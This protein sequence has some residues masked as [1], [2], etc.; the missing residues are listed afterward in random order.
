MQF[1]DD[2]NPRQKEAVVHGDGPLLVVAGA[3]SGKTRVLTYRIAYLLK[4]NRVKPEQV[5]A[6][7][8]TN[9][10]AREMES[11]IV[12]LLGPRRLP[13]LGTFHANCVKLLRREIEPLGF[14]RDFGIY[15]TKDQLALLRR[16]LK[17]MN[18]PEQD[19]R[20]ARILGRISRAKGNLWGPEEYVRNSVSVRSTQEG[21]IYRNYQAALQRCRALDFDDIINFTVRLLEQHPRLLSHWQERFARILIDEYQDVNQAQYVLVK[22]L[23]QGHRNITAVGDDDQS[24]YGFR[25]ADSG[26]LLRFEEDFPDARVVKLEENYRST[27]IILEAANQLVRHNTRRKEKT[28]W[29]GGEEGLPITIHAA[30]DEADEARFVVDRIRSRAGDD[31]R[32]WSDY[33]ILYRTNAQSRL[34]EDALL[35][36]G[37]PYRLVGGIRFYER[38]VVK[39]MLAYLRLVATPDDSIA[40]GRIINVPPR[41]LGKT[42]LDALEKYSQDQGISFHQ[43][44]SRAADVAG[45]SP[46]A[47]ERLGRFQELIESW[48]GEVGRLPLPELISLIA[49][50]SGYRGG[51]GDEQDPAVLAELDNLEEFINLAADYVQSDQSP[52]LA[53]FLAQVALISDVD[54]WD[55][56]A[57]AVTLMTLHS[58]KGLEFPTVFL[59]GMEEG[60]FPHSRSMEV[61]AEMEEERR[62]CYVGI[63]RARERLYLTRAS[64][65]KGWLGRKDEPWGRGGERTQSQTRLPSQFLGE[66]PAHLLVNADGKPL[67]RAGGADD[68]HDE[69]AVKGSAATF[70]S[71]RRAARMSGAALP[72]GKRLPGPAFGP[73][74][75][76]ADSFQPGQRV[77]HRIFGEGRVEECQ[78]AQVKV[79]FDR[80]GVKTL[81]ADFLVAEP[82]VKPDPIADKSVHPGSSRPGGNAK[83]EYSPGDLIIHPRLGSGVVQSCADDSTRAMIAV[84]PQAGVVQV[85]ADQVRP[86]QPS[87]PRGKSRQL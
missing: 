69:G 42:T 79:A 53:G 62:L 9:K 8:F 56:E 35:Q 3:G 4:R 32:P 83:R 54:S 82:D 74:R 26:F 16:I 78:G 2:L 12:Q 6:V 61:M 1:L 46:R 28:L 39:D 27:R 29:T 13:W 72:T 57:D 75:R 19:Y 36:L 81:M 65:R 70:P 18:L 60:L 11:R 67:F 68:E 47:V 66:I 22:L 7:T 86:A 14:P 37:I 52:S 76:K 23:A 64:R 87:R 20:P 77:R 55:A 63:T 24:I 17:D 21:E 43:A 44:L 40:L 48:R 85:D 34:F 5:L 10:A 59:V 80:L 73:L 30:W 45:I 49:D 41:G 58:A 50:Q 51:L 15:D 33:A 71:P 31:R 38:K 84:F 25:G